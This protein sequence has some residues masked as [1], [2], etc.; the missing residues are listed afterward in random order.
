MIEGQITI[1]EIVNSETVEVNN[2]EVPE[3][4][5]GVVTGCA[6]LNVRKEPSKEAEVLCV[7]NELSAVVVTVEESTEDFYKVCTPSGIEGYC[8]KKFI[9][10]VV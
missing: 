1:D 2:V 3:T 4:T 6:K 10:I 5:N 8:M 9:N 7:I